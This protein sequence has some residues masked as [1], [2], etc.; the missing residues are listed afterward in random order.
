MDEVLTVPEIEKRYPSE[1]ILVADPEFD[2]HE[3]VARGRVVWHSKDRDEVYRK[4]MELRPR[5]AAYLYTGTIPDD[6]VVVL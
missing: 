1:W 2:E 6:M 4:D 5:S 3:D